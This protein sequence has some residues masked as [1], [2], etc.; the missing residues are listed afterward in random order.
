MTKEELDERIG[1][2]LRKAAFQ[3]GLD[4]DDPEVYQ[5]LYMDNL[6]TAYVNPRWYPLAWELYASSLASEIFL[7]Q[8][9]PTVPEDKVAFTIEKRPKRWDFFSN[10]H[11]SA[12]TP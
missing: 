5:N 10:A 7:V 9:D 11:F 3:V 2:A 4:M 12:N 8:S 6:V 1:V